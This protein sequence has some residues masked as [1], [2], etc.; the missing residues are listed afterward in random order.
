MRGNCT[1]V[2][3]TP[4]YCSTKLPFGKEIVK[5]LYETYTE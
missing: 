1:L 3:I 2:A 4:D 5:F